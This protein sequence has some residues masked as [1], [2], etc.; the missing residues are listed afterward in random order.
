MTEF[1]PIVSM[2]VASSGPGVLP[3]DDSDGREPVVV[4][5]LQ[6]PEPT[7]GRELRRLQGIQHDAWRVALFCLHGS[8][9]WVQAF[10]AE[11]A[12]QAKYRSLFSSV[13]KNSRAV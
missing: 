10:Y 2:L 9:V 13:R 3:A 11:G 1:T 5:R 6:L 12:G 7:R 8:P 4:Q